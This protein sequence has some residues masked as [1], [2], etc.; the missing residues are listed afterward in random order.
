MNHE[1]IMNKKPNLNNQEIERN[2]IFINA[3]RTQRELKTYQNYPLDD[4]LQEKSVSSCSQSEIKHGINNNYNK[5]WFSQ[6]QTEK[7]RE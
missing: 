3:K 5:S 4:Q 2:K 1:P 6:N 7:K